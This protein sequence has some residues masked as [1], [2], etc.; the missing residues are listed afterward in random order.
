MQGSMIELIKETI[1]SSQI[2]AQMGVKIEIGPGM[3]L[4]WPWPCSLEGAFLGG[5]SDP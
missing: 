3:T 2:I 5:I 4:F 1:R